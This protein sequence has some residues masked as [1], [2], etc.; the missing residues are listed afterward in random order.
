MNA[1]KF[2]LNVHQRI[3]LSVYSLIAI[4]CIA[5]TLSI[6][7][8]GKSVDGLEVIAQQG[9]P[10]MKI[11]AQLAG[12]YDEIGELL[13]SAANLSDR[14]KL[15]KANEVSEQF[16]TLIEQRIALHPEETEAFNTLQAEF[17]NNFEMGVKIANAMITGDMS[18]VPSLMTPYGDSIKTIKQQ[19]QT[20]LSASESNFEDGLVSMQSGLTSSRSMMQMTLAIVFLAGALVAWLLARSI[21][22]PI[23]SISDAIEDIA[24][25]D[26]DL[27]VRLAERGKDELG[28]LTHHFNSLLEK[29][30]GIIGQM[31][32][33]SCSLAQSTE[34]IA[35]QNRQMADG[36]QNQSHQALKIA[37]AMEQMNATV[38]E[39]SRNSS[40]AADSAREAM[41][42]A[43]RGGDVIQQTIS[44]MD[45]LASRVSQSTQTIHVLG[46][47]TEKIGEIVL[48]IDEI[49]D[50]TNLLALNA[51]IEAARAGDQGRGFSVVA[52][53]VRKLAE[54]TTNATQE[55]ASMISAIQKETN[56]VIEMMTASQAEAEKETTL[57]NESGTA[58][59]HIIDVIS[60]VHDMV[61]QIATAAREQ[62]I[63]TDEITNN[64]EGIASV[65]E[66]TSK[67]IQHSAD[68]GQKL[69]QMATDLNSVV[70][71][72]KLR[73]HDNDHTAAE[74]VDTAPA[75]D[76]IEMSA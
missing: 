50:Q 71:Q 26:G 4:F 20:N 10:S 23:I 34:T 46:T 52:D 56:N 73:G 14:E 28:I 53:E 43:T 61:E 22:C 59:Q 27:T 72:F 17:S 8:A 32:V 49:A 64:V 75:D 62:A 31:S 3:L 19:L 39:V 5:G 35:E 44:G 47:N 21:V 6:L 29:F 1:P 2:N 51:A 9:Y 12:T 66:A 11:D 38:S 58:L 69:N 37:A 7:T 55:I 60:G 63:A 24:N 18:E 76:T 42:I 74:V 15:S 36:A 25:G 65:T 33:T 30:H 45:V 54:R 57:V 16:R 13:Y 41:S 48:V 68:A 67:R 70:S 40:V